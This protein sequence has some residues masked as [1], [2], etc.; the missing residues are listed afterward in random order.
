MRRRE[1]EWERRLRSDL[2]ALLPRLR[3]FAAGLSG[4][5]EEGDDLVQAACER[6]LGRWHQFQPGT[7]LDSWMYR[8][9]QTQWLDRVRH[10]R[11]SPE[12]PVQGA[13]AYRQV[14]GETAIDAKLTLDSVRREIGHLPEN[15]R[16]VL[17]LVCGEGLT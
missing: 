2:V 4:S 15:Q 5:I 7:R 6:A 14:D 1:V 9:I 16:V 11:R 12:E 8:I 3:R 17:L 13:G 10:R